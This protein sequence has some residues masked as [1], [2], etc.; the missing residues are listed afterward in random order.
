MRR[1]KPE[2]IEVDHKRLRDVA[3][4]A[5]E[6]LDPNDAELF[7]RVFDAYEYV[8]G[9]IGEK[10]MSIGRLQKMLFGAKTE[11]TDKVVGDSGKPQADSGEENDKRSTADADEADTDE[12]AAE[13]KPPPQGHGRN[14]AAAYRGAKRIEV[15]HDSLEPGDACPECGQ[16]TV[17][18]KAPGV[19]VRITGQAPLG[20][21]RY[22]LQK[23]RCG[24]CGK[25]FTAKL[26]EAAGTQKYDAKAAGMI[27]LLKYGSGLPFNRLA[28]LQRDLEIP[29]PAST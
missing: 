18:E 12:A 25:V 20:A 11:K 1:K 21:T 17:Y 6:S 7:G 10:N 24:L 14:G 27:G 9:L 19:V 22:E 29:L 3:D 5:K 8:A 4:R 16:G 15:P 2:I 26:P 23:L 13:G 28:G